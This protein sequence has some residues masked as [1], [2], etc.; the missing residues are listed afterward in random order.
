MRDRGVELKRTVPSEEGSGHEGVLC[1][2]F[3][4]ASSR[5]GDAHRARRRVLADLSV[6]LLDGVR[7]EL[8]HRD[9]SEGMSAGAFGVLPPGG[10]SNATYLL[11]AN[12]L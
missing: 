11:F 3:G 10:L 9:P 1:P 6:S 2:G 12:Q 5:R 4:V 7:T 8:V